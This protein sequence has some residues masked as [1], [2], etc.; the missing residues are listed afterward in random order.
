MSPHYLAD[1]P[2]PQVVPPADWAPGLAAAAEVPAGAP[3][4]R[5]AA[6]PSDSAAR[7]NR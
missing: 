4:A 3:A 1:P 2:E 5:P 6:H 7:R